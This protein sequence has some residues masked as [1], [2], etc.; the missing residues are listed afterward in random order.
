MDEAGRKKLWEEYAK[1]K[2]PEIREKI[3]LEYAPL[4]KVVAGRLSMYLGYNVEYEDLV[5]YG[6]FGLIDAIDKFDFLKDVKFETYAS[7][8]IR[9]A[10]LDQIR[11]MDW[12]PRTIRQKQKKIDAV[13]RDIEARYGRSATDEEV[14]S[15]LGI[16][17]EEYL[18]WQSQ[19][20]ITNVVSLNEFLEQGSEV[21]NEASQSRS[22][23]F[24]SPE[25]VLERDELKKMLTESLELLTEKE[26][27][28][29]V[30]YYYEDLTLK[31][32]SNI[33]GV[34]ESRIS[35][36]H[37]RALQKMRTKMGN[38]IGILTQTGDKR[39]R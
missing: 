18:D 27:K 14:S 16:T 38:Y 20:K 35:Q 22:S 23:Q 37:T 24:D 5:S 6:I 28:V 12:I 19:M 10:I 30:F 21:P 34:S 4:V 32:I 26:R 3:I 1:A 36:L 33:L 29:I 7:L 15:G 11:K 8:R 25:E 13:I 31:E 39:R 2:S 17:E 9:G